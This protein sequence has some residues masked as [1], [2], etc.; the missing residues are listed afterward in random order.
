MLPPAGRRCPG[1]SA[2]FI[3][4]GPAQRGLGGGPGGGPGGRG[5]LGGLGGGPGGYG[6]RGLQKGQGK[7]K[8]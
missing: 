5:G 4:N 6:G 7:K 2:F 8:H 1:G 3:M